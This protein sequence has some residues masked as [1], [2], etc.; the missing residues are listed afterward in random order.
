MGLF[1]PTTV[2]SAAQCSPYIYSV[3]GLVVALAQ[4]HTDFAIR[5]WIALNFAIRHWIA[6]NFAI[7]H[8]IALNLLSSFFYISNWTALFPSFPS[9]C[10][11]SLFYLCSWS[12]IK[13]RSHVDLKGVWLEFML[14]KRLLWWWFSWFYHVAYARERYFRNPCQIIFIPS[15]DFIPPFLLYVSL[16]ILSPISFHFPFSLSK[17][18]PFARFLASATK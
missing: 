7:R 1:F 6:L 8:C 12:K 15:S 17:L 9:A 4:G 11:R 16:S 10:T 18:L 2:C 3:W 5:H 13:E 14:G